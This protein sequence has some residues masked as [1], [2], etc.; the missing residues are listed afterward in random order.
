MKKSAEIFCN[1]IHN[2]FLGV[3]QT[4]NKGLFLCIITIFVE[5][6]T[7]RNDK[8]ER[9]MVTMTYVLHYIN[10]H[11]RR[12]FLLLGNSIVQAH[13][14]CYLCHISMSLYISLT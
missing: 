1:G 2:P 13:A 11:L 5:I 6:P 3:Q 10:V 12:M 4:Y 7:V 14:D 9:D 8:R